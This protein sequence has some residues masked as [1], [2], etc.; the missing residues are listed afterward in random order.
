MGYCVNLTDCK[1][2]ILKDNKAK[3]LQAIKELMG[4]VNELRSNG[5]SWVS[6]DDVL[7][8]CSF[9]EA[10]ECWR[11]PVKID[12]NG[13][14]VDIE[15]DGEKLGEEGLM[16]EAIAPYVVAGSYLQYQGDDGSIWRFVFDGKKMVD[17]AATIS[18]E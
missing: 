2:D 16:F 17:K 10:M 1:F 5:F 9:E 15:F 18:F 12:D 7:A 11:Y 8:S 13:D 4:K 3:A 14:I 6:T